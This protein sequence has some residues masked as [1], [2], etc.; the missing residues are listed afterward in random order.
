MLFFSAKQA[1]KDAESS[2]EKYEIDK[3]VLLMTINELFE[4]YHKKTFAI[5]QANFKG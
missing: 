4:G 2:F 5:F 1:I 3:N